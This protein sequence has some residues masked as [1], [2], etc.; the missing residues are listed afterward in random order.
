M[1]C[2]KSAQECHLGAV[3]KVPEYHPPRIKELYPHYL[4]S[5]HECI[6]YIKKV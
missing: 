4:N 5:E 1:H 2:R 6:C 3:I